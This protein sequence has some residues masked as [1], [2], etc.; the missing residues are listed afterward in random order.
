MAQIEYNWGAITGLAREYGT[1]RPFIYSLLNTFKEELGHL[2][3][4]KKMPDPISREMVEARILAY[5][6]EGRSSIDAIS[7]LLKRDGMPFS[8]HGFVSEFLTRVGKMLPNTLR[9]ENSA[10]PFVVFANDEVFSK[11]KP[12]LITV[13][14]VSSAILRIELTDSRTAEKWS[15]HYRCIL[16][17]G[18]MPE[19]STSDAGVAICAANKETLPD[20]PWQLDTFHSVAHRLGLWD[21][22]LEKAISTAV[23]YAADREKKLSSAKSDT[24]IEKRLNSC[25]DAEDAITKACEL[26]DD[27]HY[28]YIEIIHQLN[29]FDSMGE[30][31]KRKD[32]EETIEIALDLM[33]S[34]DYTPIKKDIASVRKALPDFLTYFATA[35][36]AVKN[37]QT[38]SDNNDA[39]KALYLAWQWDKAVIKSKETTRKHKA[40]EQ[41]DL[42]L[43]LAELFVENKAQYLALQQKIYKELDKII[44]ASSMVEC[45]NS[46]LRPYLNNSKNQ[47]TQEFL[48]TF[49]FYHNNRRYHAGKR[50]NKTPMEILTGKTQKEDWIGLLQE[51]IK[52]QESFLLA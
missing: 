7:T 21:R 52:K 18:F 19:F 16:D 26:H 44:Q 17:N 24:V 10:V 25:C 32:A 14:P 15:N 11:S 3:F 48:N 33:E 40:I 49:M 41:R 51:E 8:A 13:D 22:K 37:G 42:H 28:L 36:I 47:V 38:F 35:E 5:R 50:K 43:E 12:I 27:F 1:S 39:L 2:L 45:I 46:L 9:N 31:R 30:L 23:L 6:F 4:P 20:I 29:S 34:L